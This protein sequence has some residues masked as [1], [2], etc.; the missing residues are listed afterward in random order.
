MLTEGHMHMTKSRLACC[1]YCVLLF[2]FIELYW[3][4]YFFVL[5]GFVC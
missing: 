1:V 3:A 5:F 4:A 2:R